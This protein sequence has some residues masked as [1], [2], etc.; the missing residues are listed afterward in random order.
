MTDPRNRRL[1]IDIII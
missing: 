1:Q